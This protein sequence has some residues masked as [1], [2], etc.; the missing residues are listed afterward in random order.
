LGAGLGFGFG[1]GDA[2]VEACAKSE[3][4]LALAVAIAPPP[5]ACPVSRIPSSRF[6]VSEVMLA[7]WEPISIDSRVVP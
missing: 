4:K 3:S 6:L 7:F 2:Q 1:F 5:L